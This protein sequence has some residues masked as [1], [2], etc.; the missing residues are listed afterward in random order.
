MWVTPK[1]TLGGAGMWG[2]VRTNG[3]IVLQHYK[4]EGTVLGGLFSSIRSLYSEAPTYRMISVNQPYWEYA[5]GHGQEGLETLMDWIENNVI[6]KITQHNLGGYNQGNTDVKI[7]IL[8]DFMSSFVS[9]FGTLHKLPLSE[10]QF[11]RVVK[12]MTEVPNLGNSQQKAA[13]VH[14]HTVSPTPP[15]VGPQRVIIQPNTVSSAPFAHPHIVVAQ[16]PFSGSQLVTRLERDPI[17]GVIRQVQVYQ[18]TTSAHNL[19]PPSEP[20]QPWSPPNAPAQ[21]P[22]RSA[23]GSM[24]YPG[25]SYQVTKP[26]NAYP[27]PTYA[28]AYPGAPP[29]QNHPSQSPAV[30]KTSY[31]YP[32]N[33]ANPT[34]P[35]HSSSSF[36]GSYAQPP[37]VQYQPPRA[38]P[39]VQQLPPNAV[40][41]PANAK[42]YAIPPTSPPNNPYIKPPPSAS[43]NQDSIPSQLPISQWDAPPKQN[44]SPSSVVAPPERPSSAPAAPTI[45]APPPSD[46]TIHTPASEDSKPSAPKYDDDEDRN[47]CKLCF[48]RELDCALLPCSHVVCYQCATSLKLT[49]CPFC[50]QEI[51]KV[52][53]LYR[54]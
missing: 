31:Y 6:T 43:T 35:G 45:P 23:S 22:V 11:L 3:I 47:L 41:Q 13:I 37:P 34:Y 9:I 32:P 5:N 8:T 17:T 50:R 53:K 7:R 30:A 28:P 39:S 24:V 38:A 26:A 36:S 27:Q 46:V 48:E 1:P 16:Q 54:A 10:E 2:E 49:T 42:V 40:A 44:N 15:Q 21:Q 14:Q 52:L 20:Y 29:P 19:N 18:P 4:P 25:N 12:D 51:T 33:Q